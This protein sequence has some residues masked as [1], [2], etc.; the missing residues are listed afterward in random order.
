MAT[1]V[2]RLIIIRIQSKFDSRKVVEITMIV[3]R[4]LSEIQDSLQDEFALGNEL[5]LRQHLGDLREK[6]F[7]IAWWPKG[8]FV[9]IAKTGTVTWEQ[10]VVIFSTE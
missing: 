10:S 8:S 5:Y 9:Q 6:S 3:K 1:V 7:K 2:L 4:K